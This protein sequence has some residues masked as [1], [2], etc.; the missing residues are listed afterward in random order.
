MPSLVL[1]KYEILQPLAEG[2]MGE[3]L[4]ARQVGIPG[5]ERLV[6]LKRLRPEL[7]LVPGVLEQFLDEA[8]IAAAMNHPHLVSLYE[9][10][11]DEGPTPFRS[12]GNSDGSRPWYIVM[13]YIHGENLSWL[14]M[15]Q[16]A[17]GEQMPFDVAACIVRDAALGLDHAHHAVDVGGRPLHVVHRDVTPQNIMLRMDGVTKVVDFGIA[18][19]ANRTTRTEAGT[20]KGK[21]SYMP[22]E[23][24]LREPLDGRT[25]Q[26]ALGV[27][28]WEMLTGRRLFRGTS[29][30]AVFEEILA[31]RIPSARSVRPE[32][33]AVLDAVVTRMLSRQ[34]DDRYPRLGLVATELQRFLEQCGDASSAP[35]AAYMRAIA[36]GHL[37][38]RLEGL[39]APAREE[40]LTLEARTPSPR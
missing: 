14:L 23:Q 24:I 28:F 21:T 11:R 16:W 6:I 10:S 13:E 8:R 25:D 38:E 5:F 33:P 2:G 32:V 31:G 29:D 15:Q 18:T 39:V 12:T 34:R 37:G 40:A 20:V 1:G 19:G 27:V 35:A 7:V 3:L 36:T 30:A 26:F 9:V 22:P 17:R 4:L